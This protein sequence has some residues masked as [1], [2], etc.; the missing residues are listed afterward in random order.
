MARPVLVSAGG[1][2]LS[3]ICTC[4]NKLGQVMSWVTLRACAAL[5]TLHFSPGLQRANFD[6]LS[7]ELRVMTEP[8]V[9]DQIIPHAT[10]ELKT[11]SVMTNRN[12]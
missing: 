4:K 12:I 6:K 3:S 7:E 9:T 8:E 1:C 10:S 5:R 11:R 2:D